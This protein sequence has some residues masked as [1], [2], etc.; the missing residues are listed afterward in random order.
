MNRGIVM[1]VTSRSLI[2]MTPDGEFKKVSKPNRECHIG[3]E[4]QFSAP[5]RTWR[6]PSRSVASA[7]T[8]AVLLCII[9]LSMFG[10]SGGGNTVVAYVALDINPSLELGINAD[11]EVIAARGIN[12]EGEQLLAAIEYKGVNVEKVTEELIHTV[13]R[14]GYLAD[15]SGDI[16]ITSTIVDED[17]ALNETKMTERL[18]NKVKAII[19]KNHPDHEGNIQVAK[20]TAPKEV[21]EEAVNKGI[22]TGKMAVNLIAN[23]LIRKKNG[24]PIPLEEFEK[25]SIHEVAKELGGLGKLINSAVP[26][27]KAELKQLLKDRK[28]SK[29]GGKGNTKKQDQPVVDLNLLNS[30]DEDEADDED[31]GKEDSKGVR[32]NPKHKEDRDDGNKPPGGRHKGAND[33]RGDG[34]DDDRGKPV[35]NSLLGDIDIDILPFNPL[36]YRDES[37]A[38]K[39]EGERQSVLPGEKR[40]VNK[41][42]DDDRDHDR[43]AKADR[44]KE[45]DGNQDRPGRSEDARG[46]DRANDRGSERSNN[47]GNN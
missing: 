36:T 19:E 28:N 10:G 29:R 40:P 42:R 7:L 44:D 46:N 27:T 41:E 2:V 43:D 6:I 34:H 22:S 3:E 26:V 39:S 35:I 21:R 38:T 45:V 33:K 4:I 13:E 32:G 20:L 16:L 23:D 1:Q 30:E 15:G 8:A 47:R 14:E 5:V 9:V 25:H 17:A 12:S 31:E 37:N 18:E 24:V 11:Q